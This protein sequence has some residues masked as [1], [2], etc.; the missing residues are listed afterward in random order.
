MP[1]VYNS[2]IVLGSEVLIDLTAD[3]VTPQTLLSGTSAHDASGA[4]ITGTC[5]YDAYTGDADALASEVISG[6]TFYK[7]GQKLTGSM[8]NR[9]AVSLELTN[10]DTPVTI[11]Q[12]YHDG[13]GTVGLGSSDL[14][15]LVASNVRENVTILGVTGTMSGSEDM[16]AEAV[17]ITP[18]LSQQ[19][20]LPTS[21]TYNC[22]SQATVEAV[23]V[24]RVVNASGGYTVSICPVST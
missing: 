22:I 18:S 13:S 8:T 20:V 12:G 17:T 14:E 4:P 7:N 5:N 15:A 24:T 19:T 3:T 6:K 9:G 11:P 16:H 1:E 2:K 21:P 23:P 10:S